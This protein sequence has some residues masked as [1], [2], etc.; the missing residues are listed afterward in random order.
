M[1]YCWP[2]GSWYLA[3]QTA[4]H[5]RVR[6]ASRAQLIY[7]AQDISTTL[8]IVL[9][10][11]RRFGVLSKERL[12]SALHDLVRPGELNGIAL[13]N[14]AGDVVASAGTVADFQTKG[15]EGPAERWDEQTV[16]LMNLVDLGTNVTRDIESNRPADRFAPRRVLS[17]VRYQPV[18]RRPRARATTE[19]RH[20]KRSQTV[21]LSRRTRLRNRRHRALPRIAPG[22]VVV[23]ADRGS[24]ARHG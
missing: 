9:R 14:A 16:T 6:R 20:R 12:E 24:V 1:D 4:E 21:P 13:L 22:S 15:V 10:S 23:R 3:W 17:P 18:R 5:F 2:R 11:Q 7:R 19:V 8:G